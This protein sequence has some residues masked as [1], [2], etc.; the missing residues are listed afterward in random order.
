MEKVILVGLIALLVTLLLFSGCVSEVDET[1]ESKDTPLEDRGVAASNG[2]TGSNGVAVEPKD[3]GS[4]FNWNYSSVECEAGIKLTVQLEYSK[5][6]GVIVPM[7]KEWG[8]MEID[9]EKFE[10]YLYDYF[11]LEL[12][13]NMEWNILDG[14]SSLGEHVLKMGL[15]EG[16]SKEYTF[17]CMTKEDL[18][19]DKICSNSEYSTIDSWGGVTLS[20]ES[21]DKLKEKI[22]SDG[23]VALRGIS[24]L[25]CIEKLKLSDVNI[26]DISPLTSLKNLESL[27]LEGSKVDDISPLA[28][29]TSLKYLHMIWTDASKEDCEDL[30]K[31][32]PDT[33]I[34]CPY[35]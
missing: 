31:A 16:T 10:K 21:E 9:G 5:A 4:D 26:S 24:D 1:D 11:G 14:D 12:E 6:D 20:K 32:L 2:A 8:V 19:K 35:R 27:N 17:E 23:D 25:T 30:Q 18:V 29:I 13:G 15:T 34:S 28:E 22:I 3:T 33:L 7:G